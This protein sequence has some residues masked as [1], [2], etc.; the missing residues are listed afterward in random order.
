VPHFPHQNLFVLFLI[1]C[2]PHIV[3]CHLQS[4]I[5]IHLHHHRHPLLLLLLR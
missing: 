5:C 1:H 4:N 2:L 3:L